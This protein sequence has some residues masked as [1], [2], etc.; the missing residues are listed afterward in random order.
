MILDTSAVL[1]I[2]FKEAEA[3]PLARIVAESSS[4]AIAG[5]TLV[6]TGIVLGSQL[7]FRITLLHRF[8]QEAQVSIVPFGEPHWQ[9][10]VSAYERYGKGRHPAGLNFGDCFSYAAAK[11]FKQALLCK[12]HDFSQT[13]LVLVEY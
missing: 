6:E 7:D 9:M 4:V 5:P 12:G 8:L 3:K 13:D 2:L 1:A 11:L 10:A